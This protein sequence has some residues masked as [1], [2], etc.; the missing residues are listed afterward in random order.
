MGNLGNVTILRPAVARARAQFDNIVTMAP[1][2]ESIVATL[3]KVNEEYIRDLKAQFEVAEIT[4]E[5]I[6]DVYNNLNTPAQRK[7]AAPFKI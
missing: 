2:K 4:I 5:A 7:A 3:Y 1:F 6:D